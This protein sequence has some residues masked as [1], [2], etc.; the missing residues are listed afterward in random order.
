MC[1]TAVESSVTGSSGLCAT[2]GPSSYLIY[3]SGVRAGAKWNGTIFSGSNN[4]NGGGV[5]VSG[6]GGGCTSYAAASGSL[7]V[8]C[9]AAAYSVPSLAIAVLLALVAA[10]F[11]NQNGDQVQK[12]R[13]T[14]HC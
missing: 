10:L 13:N 8:Q 5:F 9:G 11:A 7:M 1:V 4:C 3:C 2:S 12:L 6:T 14:G